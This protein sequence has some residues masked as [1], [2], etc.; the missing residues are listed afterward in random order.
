MDLQS[1]YPAEYV[2]GFLSLLNK[3]Y[4]GFSGDP[5]IF[6][7]ATNDPGVTRWLTSFFWLEALFQLPIFFLGIHALRK[8]VLY[9]TS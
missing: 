4:I 6:G 3:L 8:G 2:P 1:L 7:M 5:I 9:I